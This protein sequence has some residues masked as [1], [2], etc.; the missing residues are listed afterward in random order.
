[1]LPQDA[2]PRS[3][4]VSDAMLDVVDAETRGIGAGAGHR[5]GVTGRRF[6]QARGW[7]PVGVLDGAWSRCRQTSI[8]RGRNRSPCQLLR[9]ATTLTVTAMI[10]TSKTKDMRACRSTVSRISVVS[11]AVSATWKV[12]PMVKA[13]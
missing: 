6:G 1:V 13:R 3:A 11:S 2:E 4:G 8:R 7:N 5:E 10:T 12:I 9:P